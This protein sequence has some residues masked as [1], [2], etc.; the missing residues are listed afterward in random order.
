MANK[1]IEHYR[2]EFKTTGRKNIEIRMAVRE[3]TYE[4]GPR[5]W[6]C[7]SRFVCTFFVSIKSRC[8]QTKRLENNT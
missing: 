2:F 4:G 5:R 1:G 6:N 3:I 7:W 8:R